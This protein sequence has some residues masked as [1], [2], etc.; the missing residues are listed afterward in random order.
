MSEEKTSVTTVYRISD[1]GWYE[2][3]HKIGAHNV[4]KIGVVIDGENNFNGLLVE[5]KKPFGWFNEQLQFEMK[6]KIIK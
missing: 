4:E 3:V 6:T 1:E 2:I 5:Y